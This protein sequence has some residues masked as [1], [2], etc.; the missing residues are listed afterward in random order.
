MEERSFLTAML[1]IECVG[2]SFP[3]STIGITRL[4]LLDILKPYI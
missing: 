1:R 4:E 3:H 2:A